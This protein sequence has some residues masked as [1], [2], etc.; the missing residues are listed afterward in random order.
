MQIPFPAL[1]DG[2]DKEMGYPTLHNRDPSSVLT[3]R[4]KLRFSIRGTR[5]ISHPYQ[6]PLYHIF[7]P[8]ARPN[9]RIPSVSRPSRLH[10]S[11][12]AFGLEIGI[13]RAE[14]RLPEVTGIV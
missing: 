8:K 9:K 3:S 2:D 6:K 14:R 11:A 7:S 13:N 5:R 1:P 4:F 10:W 12:K